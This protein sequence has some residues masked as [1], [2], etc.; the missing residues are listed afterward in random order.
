MAAT[1]SA[2]SAAGSAGEAGGA[3][4]GDGLVGGEG[5]GLAGD[6]DAARASRGQRRRAG[7]GSR[8]RPWCAA[9][10]RRGAAAAAAAGSAPRR[11]PRRRPGCGRRR[12]RARPAPAASTSGPRRRRCSRAGHSAPVTAAAQAASSS[13]ERR[14]GRRARCRRSRPGARRSARGRGRSSRPACVEEG[15]A[16]VLLPDLPVVVG[17]RRAARRPRSA[18]ASIAASASGGC[19][20]TTQGTPGFRMPAF[21]PAISARVSPRYCWWSS[22]TGVMA[23]EPRPRDDVGRVEPAAEADLE[24]GPVGRG[25]G[26]REEGGGGG[27]LEEGDR[28]A[29]VRGLAAFEQRRRAGPRRSARRRGGCA[30]GSGRGAARCRRGPRAPVGL[31]AGAQ[32]GDDRALAVGAGDVD[33]RRQPALGVAE[34]GEQPLDAAERQVDDLGVQRRSAGRGPG[35]CPAAHCAAAWAASSTGAGRSPCT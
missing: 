13:A 6:R 25:L 20:P 18:R 1:A 34:R 7:G 21:S 10:R 14:A 15:H 32:H 3:G 24:Q 23:A 8:R 17:D 19:R 12:A 2:T 31:E 11:A 4:G 26:H 33:H 28:R 16:A 9:C 35:R 30:R 27:D 22:E 29:A 5:R